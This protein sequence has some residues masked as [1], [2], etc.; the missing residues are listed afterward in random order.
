MNTFT[1][2]LS[3]L[4]LNSINSLSFSNPIRTSLGVLLGYVLSCAFTLFKPW[5][6]SY[7][8]V[9]WSGNTVVGWIAFGVLILHLPYYV[10]SVFNKSEINE[11][12]DGVIKL[13]EKSNLF[14]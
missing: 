2:K 7:G 10:W 9:D 13:I 14:L 4:L 3:G 6:Q 5:F 1:E 8:V 11:K 12:V